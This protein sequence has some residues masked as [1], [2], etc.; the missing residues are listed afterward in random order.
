MPVQDEVYS[1][2]DVSHS[3]RVRRTVPRVALGV[4]ATATIAVTALALVE[5]RS[6]AAQAACRAN[7]QQIG[8]ALHAYHDA[9]HSFPPAHVRGPD[10]RLWHSWRVLILPNLGEEQLYRQYR[11]DEPWD[12]PH[13]RE[14]IPRMP[15][16]LACPGA[17]AEAGRT[18]YFAVVSPRT[19]WPAHQS[20]AIRDVIDGTSNTVHVVE[21]DSLN[22]VWTEPRDLSTVEIR[23]GMSPSLS[24]HEGSG[25]PAGRH[26]LFV[27]GSVRFLAHTLDRSR[28]AS[29]LTPAYGTARISEADW[30]ADL[31]RER[32]EP[33]FGPPRDVDSLPETGISATRDAELQAGETVLWC[34]TFQMA[35][36]L[37]RDG[38]DD[39][40]V[41]LVGSPP[42]ARA[43]NAWRFPVEALSPDC[44]LIKVDGVDSVSTGRLRAEVR[45]RFPRGQPR[46]AP[47]DDYGYGGI[48]FYAYL[49]K[50]MPFAQEFD[51]LPDGL[52]FQSGTDTAAVEGFGLSAGDGIGLGEPI[53]KEQVLVR[54]Y[55][56]DDD[57]VLELATDGDQK[58]SI[59]LAKVAPKE[60]LLATWESVQQRIK[61]PDRW[62]DRPSLMS[63]E[64]L[65]VPLL[66]FDLTGTF[67][68]LLGVD[69]AWQNMR[70]RL[71]ELGAD[72]ISE[73][74]IAN[75]S[76]ID[77]I[78][79]DRPPPPK[80]RQ[81]F[82]DR[83]F[84]IVLREQ[85][86]AE[87]YFIGWI[88][89]ADLMERR[90]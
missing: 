36:D 65:A 68:E 63:V 18:S 67:H 8:L 16:W 34:A 43:L 51:R 23:K 14:L 82:F 90:R 46:V 87:P 56:S 86:A 28:L 69:F 84:L 74:E 21:D 40:D 25:T 64:P 17:A 78:G 31:A 32:P 4:V 26:F 22:V 88:G 20:L 15:G 10:G 55:V 80:P 35:W 24:L 48:R 72:F 27:D 53:F 33:D 77:D 81:F 61:S 70:L 45:D 29:L 7:L 50:R 73:A 38:K 39:Q 71:D 59:F 9:Y 85:Q 2:P 5:G 52:K 89:N 37:M 1:I 58:D 60:S 54:D 19:M 12:G 49:E 6:R 41:A 30:P 79:G 11:F 57:F 83:P 62:H 3:G 44:Y 47:I 75:V 76:S 13:N 42:L 66:V